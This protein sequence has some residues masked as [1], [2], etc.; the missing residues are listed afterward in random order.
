MRRLV[1]IWTG[2]PP[3]LQL[4]SMTHRDLACRWHLGLFH[5]HYRYLSSIGLHMYQDDLRSLSQK[6]VT[7]LEL[8]KIRIVLTVLSSIPELY[9][10]TALESWVVWG[11]A[12]Y[13]PRRM[14][15]VVSINKTF[16]LCDMSLW[17]NS[18]PF[19]VKS[20]SERRIPK[21][22]PLLRE[23]CSCDTRRYWDVFCITIFSSPAVRHSDRARTTKKKS[24]KEEYHG[25]K[26]SDKCYKGFI[27]SRYLHLYQ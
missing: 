7:N 19:V 8:R 2:L 9:C 25:T 11:L 12:A 21:R 3:A 16:S 20:S 26:Y 1:P 4:K 23:F 6:K 18:F 22:E 5:V 14:F 13:L 15:L 24:W 17:T 27:P 10:F